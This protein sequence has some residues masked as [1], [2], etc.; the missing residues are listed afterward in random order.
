MRHKLVAGIVSAFALFPAAAQGTVRYAA[1]DGAASGDCTSPSA[2]CRLARAVSAAVTAPG[3]EIVVA[4]GNYSVSATPVTIGEPIVVHG[5]VGQAPPVILDG[6]GWAVTIAAAASGATLR[7]VG[8]VSTGDDSAADGALKVDAPLADVEDVDVEADSTCVHGNA[9]GQRY[10]DVDAVGHAVVQRCVRLAPG[11]TI[12]RMRARADATVAV[13]ESPSTLEDST[14]VSE[15]GGGLVL[16]GADDAGVVRRVVVDAALEGAEVSGGR[17]TITD[18]VLT[19][20]AGGFPAASAE[21]ASLK[22]RN[23]TAIATGSQSDGVFVDQGVTGATSVDARN[24]IVRGTRGDFAFGESDGC[25][26]CEPKGLDVAFSNFR[27]VTGEGDLEGG[28]GNQSGDPRFVGPG[29]FRLADD[30]P[31]ID[32]GTADELGPSALDGSARVQGVAVDMG[33]HERAAAPP[34]PPP[35]PPPGAPPAP[36][37]PPPLVVLPPDVVKPRLT[38][39]SARRE[40]SRIV[41]KVASSENATL[42][43]TLSRVVRGR[44]RGGRCVTSAPKPKKGRRCTKA[45]R[46]K[47]MPGS[48]VAGANTVRLLAGTLAPGPYRLRIVA[49][50]AAGNVSAAQVV[51]FRVRR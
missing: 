22:L 21:N 37:P 46:V 4:S 20:S 31:A 23:V 38:H 11:S 26:P 5:I 27:T 43:A 24:V 25:T 48:V 45:R 41:L 33:A 6:A 42:R 32:A 40:G 49:V 44:R 36:A 16:G 7:R 47:Q 39:A 30:S 29:D 13:L 50:D 15:A 35:P 14:F 3:D 10:T 2:P 34:P 51:R 8:I 17:W 1:P 9:G 18:S 19:S 28:A 12:T